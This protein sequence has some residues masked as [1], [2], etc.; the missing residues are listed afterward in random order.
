MKLPASALRHRAKCQNHQGSQ[1]RFFSQ[2][3]HFFACSSHQK[4]PRP[5]H[6]PGALTM[7]GW[8]R[9]SRAAAMFRACQRLSFASGE[10]VRGGAAADSAR[11]RLTTAHRI[12]K[13]AAIDLRQ[14]TTH[15]HTPHRICAEAPTPTG[16]APR[17]PTSHSHTPHRICAEAPTLY[18]HT[19]YNLY[20]LPK[21][22]AGPSEGLA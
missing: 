21:P 12:V 2:L 3:A 14:R 20:A 22:P 15:S 8:R 11:T 19:T 17:C 5:K 7:P 10:D 13:N 1:I 16:S 18:T 4:R 6:A 9:T